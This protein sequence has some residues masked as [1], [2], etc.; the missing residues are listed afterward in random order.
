MNSTA[1]HPDTTRAITEMGASRNRTPDHEDALQSYVLS[2]HLFLKQ[3]VAFPRYSLGCW[4]SC[5]DGFYYDTD[6]YSW[7]NLNED[8]PRIE[9]EMKKIVKKTSHLFV[10]KSLKDRN[11]EIF[12]TV[13]TSW[14]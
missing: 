12:K 2:C 3:L 13:L 6:T 10:R 8:L 1:N 9:E 5:E 7:S 11:V 4:S 14:N